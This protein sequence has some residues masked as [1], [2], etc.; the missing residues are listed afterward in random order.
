M[1]AIIFITLLSLTIISCEESDKRLFE[2]EHTNLRVNYY[3]E[4]CEG[5][6]F[7]QCLLDSRRQSYWVK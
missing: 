2:Q 1:K 5:V 6:I 4:E 3:S 7:Q